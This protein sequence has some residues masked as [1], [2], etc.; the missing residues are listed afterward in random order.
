MNLTKENGFIHIIFISLFPLFFT[1]AL[2]VIIVG[3]SILELTKLQT[4]C[5]KA[6]KASQ[7]PLRSGIKKI[8]ALNKQAQRL[9]LQRKKAL[10][11]LRLA[12]MT[13][14]PDYAAAKA[15]LMK[16]TL[17]QALFRAKQNFILK[18]AKSLAKT[19][20]FYWAQKIKENKKG[21]VFKITKPQLA[22]TPYP[23]NSLSPSYKIKPNFESQQTIKAHL[24]SSMLQLLGALDFKWIK[25]YLDFPEKLSINCAGTLRKGK[26]WNIKHR[27]A[28]L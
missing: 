24:N 9:R 26:P 28:N 12:E 4:F 6:T 21:R 19:R 7:K 5:L 13:F 11:R 20:Q 2:G 17:K 22:I 23:S 16:I 14:S 1:L 8:M 3:L 25:G 15:H 18:T 10:A 27:P